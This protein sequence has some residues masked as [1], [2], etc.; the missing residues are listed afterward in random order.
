MASFILKGL[1][2]NDG[3]NREKWHRLFTKGK[4][5]LTDLHTDCSDFAG[6][7]PQLTERIEKAARKS[8]ELCLGFKSNSGKSSIRFKGTLTNAPHC[9]FTIHLPQKVSPGQWFCVLHQFP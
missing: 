1:V 8:L 3:I 2:T 5:S 7:A 4:I 6:A 9:P